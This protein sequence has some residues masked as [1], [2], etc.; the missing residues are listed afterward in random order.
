MLSKYGT[1]QVGISVEVALA[2]LTNVHVEENYRR[3]AR[4]EL[5]NHI[6]PV[7][8]PALELFPNPISHIA[9]NQNPVDFLL[10]QDKTLSVKSNMRKPKKIAPQKIGQPTSS[11][12]WHHFPHLAPKGVEMNSLTYAESSRIFKNVAYSEINELLDKYWENLFECNYW[13]YVYNVLDKYNDLTKTPTVM[14]LERLSTPKWTDF[15]ISFS[16]TLDNWNESCTVRINGVSIG[17][18]QV[19]NSRNCF[20]FRFN[21]AGL[22]Q[23][24]II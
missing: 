22:I 15:E 4:I 19:H 18:F 24:K 17:E 2:D 10:E 9:E 11:T 1:E 12:F 7:L 23:A 20:K 6:Q 3:R 13:L 14:V 16:R 21:I 8:I 5:I